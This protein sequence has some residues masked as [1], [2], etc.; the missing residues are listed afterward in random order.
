[1]LLETR[2]SALF[3]LHQILLKRKDEE[4]LK[5]PDLEF[6]QILL[7]LLNWIEMPW[8][9]LLPSLGETY[10]RFLRPPQQLPNGTG[11]PALNHMSSPGDFAEFLTVGQDI[12]L[13]PL[14]LRN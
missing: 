8:L 10:E 14:H 12:W 6:L 5:E 1:M 9:L 2:S 3:F 13:T 4:G 11:I 7:G